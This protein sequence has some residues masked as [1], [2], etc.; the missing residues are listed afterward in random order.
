ML[1][2]VQCQQQQSRQKITGLWEAY[3]GKNKQF[4]WSWHSFAPCLVSASGPWKS[5][6]NDCQDHHHPVSHPTKVLKILEKPDHMY[7]NMYWEH[8]RVIFPILIT[9]NSVIEARLPFNFCIFGVVLYLRFCQFLQN[10]SPNFPDFFGLL[11]ETVFYSKQP[12]KT[13]FMVWHIRGHP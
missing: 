1:L 8:F 5:L 9:V 12:S 11:F 2:I 3:L 7:V 13:E 10:K 6:I 4:S